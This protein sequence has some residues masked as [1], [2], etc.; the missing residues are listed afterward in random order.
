MK[1]LVI[2]GNGE[3]AELAWFYFSK[4]TEYNVVAFVVDKDFKESDTFC[5]LP[6]IT[7]D[8]L[9]RD[10]PPEKNSVFVAIGYNQV[11]K[12][13]ESKYLQMKE[14]G[15]SLA[16]YVS[17]NATIWSKYIGENC[18]ILE[19]NTIQPFVTIGNNVT[20]WSGNHIGHHSTIEDHCFI[21]SHVVI[22]GGVTIGHH[23]FI[24]VN[25]TL[26]D[27]I[28]VGSSNV[29]GASASIMH[30]TENDQVYVADKTKVRAIPSYKMKGI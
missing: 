6:L 11:N 22:S 21:T 25:A 27:H 5:D 10:Y 1:N 26:R 29:I 17:S 30:N 18:F 23:S 13:R 14:K 20:L 15:Y 12:L 3:Q 28:K 9:T 16:S 2:F 8:D 24:G 7:T 19:D 4:D